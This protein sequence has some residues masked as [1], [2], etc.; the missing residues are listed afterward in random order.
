M[1]VAKLANASD[2]SSD[3][4]D[5]LRVQLPSDTFHARMVELVYTVALEAT[6]EMHESPSLS[7]SI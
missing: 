6:A 7:T 4:S 2:L 5:G 1:P 3:V